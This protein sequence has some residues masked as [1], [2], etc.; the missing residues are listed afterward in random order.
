MKYIIAALAAFFMSAAHAETEARVLNYQFSEHVVVSITN[1]KCPLQEHAAKYPYAAI[2]TRTDTG[3]QLIGCF[4]PKNANDIEIQWQDYGGLKGD[5]TV[6]PANV[7]I[8]KA[9]L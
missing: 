5:V 8:P 2:A 1:L 7:F 6:F 3:A 4:G 9:T